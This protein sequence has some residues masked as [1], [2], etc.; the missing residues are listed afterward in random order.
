MLFSM[1]TIEK[2]VHAGK[3]I[4]WSFWS[5]FGQFG[6]KYGVCGPFLSNAT[7]NVPDLWAKHSFLSFVIF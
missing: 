6:P 3:I 4:E 1:E 7:T 5:N 2:H